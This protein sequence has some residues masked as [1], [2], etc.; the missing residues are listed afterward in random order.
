[1]SPV[2]VIFFLDVVDAIYDTVGSA[3]AEDVAE[4]PYD[5]LDF[6]SVDVHL[7]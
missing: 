1:M 6:A 5:A 7:G 4:E 2:K 3:C